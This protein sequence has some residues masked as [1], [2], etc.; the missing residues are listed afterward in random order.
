[1]R[2]RWRLDRGGQVD[3]LDLAF[4][5]LTVPAGDAGRL[6]DQALPADEHYAAVEAEEDP[7]L[8]SR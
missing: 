1:V 4:G 7:D 8:V 6:L 5:V 2:H 3:V